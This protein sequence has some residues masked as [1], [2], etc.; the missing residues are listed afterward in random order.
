[1]KISPSSADAF[2]VIIIGAWNPAIFTP[3]WA[4]EHLTDDKQREVV[5]AIP[6][7]LT[8]L[9][10]RLTVDD[11]NMYPSDSALVIDCAQYSD[12]A[13]DTCSKKIQRVAELLPHTPVNAVGVNFRFWGELEDSAALAEL[14]TF[15]DAAKIDSSQYK[16]TGAA[17]KRSFAITSNTVINLS[18]DSS[19]NNLR[20]EF[21]F[22]T[23]VRR[24]SEVAEKTLAGQIRENRDK[25]LGFLHAVYGVDIDS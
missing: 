3:E 20:V 19:S 11:I 5:L 9:P 17:I 25:A 8:N 23:D 22:H 1:M 16:L 6:M 10:P 21:N 18:L 12:S 7:P 15:C 14:F 13:L 24:L 4:K 2:N